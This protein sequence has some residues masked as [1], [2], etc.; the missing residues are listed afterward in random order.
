M[1]TSPQAAAAGTAASDV[2]I[3]S[4]PASASRIEFIAV[5]RGFV[6]SVIAGPSVDAVDPLGMHSSGRTRMSASFPAG[7]RSTRSSG[8]NRSDAGA[9]R[10]WRFEGL[11]AAMRP[12]DGRLVRSDDDPKARPD[13]WQ[14]TEYDLG[15]ESNEPADQFLHDVDEPVARGA[16]SAREHGETELGAPEERELWHRQEP[17]IAEDEDDG[18]KLEGFPDALIPTVLDAMGDDAAEVLPESPSGTSATGS[19]SEPDHGGF[20][21]R[22]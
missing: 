21:E 15:E 9:F 13:D 12:D 14:D 18:L 11:E 5:R 3:N 2:E 7:G 8:R 4:A 1:G 10:R 19:T 17:L 16:S 22:D 20:P 6:S